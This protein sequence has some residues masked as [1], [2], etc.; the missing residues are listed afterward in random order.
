LKGWLARIPFEILV[1]PSDSRGSCKSNQETRIDNK[2][3][4]VGEPERLL[5]G[6]KLLALLTDLA[7]DLELNLAKLEFK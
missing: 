6:Q 1:P 5:L 3:G 2:G 4:Q 7:L